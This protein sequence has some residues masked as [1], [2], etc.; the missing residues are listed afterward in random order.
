M[1]AALPEI[2]SAAERTRSRT[3][4]AGHVWRGGTAF[5][6]KTFFTFSLYVQEMYILLQ[7]IALLY[8]LLV[9]VV[10]VLV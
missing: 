10:C 1:P 5:R 6:H 7:Y 9:S 3:E 8:L 2:R 4:D